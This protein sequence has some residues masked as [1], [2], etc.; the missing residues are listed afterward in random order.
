MGVPSY[1]SRYRFCSG[2]ID[3]KGRVYFSSPEPFTY[4]DLPDNRVHISTSTDTWESLADR[5]FAAM[6]G[7]LALVGM[8]PSHLYWI[9]CDFQPEP[10]PD[11]AFDPTLRIPPGTVLV[12]PSVATVQERVFNE[13]RR[14]DFEG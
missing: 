6:A 11:A 2:L 12:I 10:Q 3:Q 7:P 8:E 1:Y 13:R 5:Y 14:A 9:L 4:L